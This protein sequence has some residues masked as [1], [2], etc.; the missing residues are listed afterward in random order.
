M[1]RIG[2]ILLRELMHALP[3]TIFF[4]VGFNLIVLT[5][6]LL[7]ADYLL[8]FAGFMVATTTALVVGKSVLVA[9]K[10]AF[11]RRFDNAPLIR[12]ILFKTFVYWGVVFIARLLEAQ[13]HYYAAGGKIGGFLVALAGEF[14]LHRFLFVQ[15]WILVLFLIYVTGAELNTLFGDGELRRILFEHRTSDLRRTRRQRI[16]ALV[17]LA[18]LTRQYPPDTFRDTSSGAYREIMELIGQLAEKKNTDAAA[19]P[20]EQTLVRSQSA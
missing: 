16:R 4:A 18:R 14:S 3:P 15:I 7:L 9:D 19:S 2:N 8:H 13:I 11:L 17:R 6:R 20:V 10:L 1:K 5:Q 12:P